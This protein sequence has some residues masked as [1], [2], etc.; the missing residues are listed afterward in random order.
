MDIQ[1][2]IVHFIDTWRCISRCQLSTNLSSLKKSTISMYRFIIQT[3]ILTVLV[4]VLSLPFR[5]LLLQILCVCL[6][7]CFATS[8]ICCRVVRSCSMPSIKSRVLSWVPCLVCI[9]MLFFFGSF[10]IP[11]ISVANSIIDRTPPCLILS[12]ILISGV[13][14]GLVWIL[15]LRFVFNFLIIVSFFPVT[16]LW[17]C[18]AMSPVHLG[19]LCMPF[20]CFS[21]ISWIVWFRTMRWS[22]V[23]LPNI[24]PA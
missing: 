14:P 15:A 8:N 16:P 7:T 21:R 20:S 23:A 2:L 5:M 24:P 10:A 1:V 18:L 17:F 3:W 22:Q 12:L 6:A 13:R 9:T 4:Q 19:I 11:S